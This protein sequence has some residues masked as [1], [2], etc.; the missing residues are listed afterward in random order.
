M[1]DEP[2]IQKYIKI[3]VQSIMGVH[4]LPPKSLRKLPSPN[5]QKKFIVLFLKR[6]E[7][8]IGAGTEKVLGGGGGKVFYTIS[9]QSLF[10]IQSVFYAISQQFLTVI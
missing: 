10:F 8:N 5:R 7:A 1:F 6:F 9:H 2:I 4:T 3:I